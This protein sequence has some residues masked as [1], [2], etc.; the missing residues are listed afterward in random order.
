MIR[1][2]LY[3]Y[4]AD[5]VAHTEDDLQL[6]VD[7]FSSSY[8]AFGLKISI[9]KTKVMF[10]PPPGLPY[11]K[12][13]IVVNGT[14]LGV[15]DTFPYLG[16]TISRD[17]ALDAEIFSCIQKA[18]KANWKHG[19]GQIGALPSRQKL[20]FISLVSWEHCCTLLKLGQHIDGIYNG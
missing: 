6:I 5:F 12:A 18:S 17:G 1:D 16:S 3:A 9:K 15:V 2:L 4:D 11:I 20:L 10:T 19:S 14:A 7:R 13:S 8:D